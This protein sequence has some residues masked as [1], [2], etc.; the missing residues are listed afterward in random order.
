MY[1]WLNFNISSRQVTI[2]RWRSLAAWTRA[3]LRSPSM[4]CFEHS[5][6]PMQLRGL[7][8]DHL[9]GGYMAEGEPVI[10]QLKYKFWIY[11]GARERSFLCYMETLVR[12]CYGLPLRWNG[13]TIIQLEQSGDSR[14]SDFFWL[15]SSMSLKCTLRTCGRDALDPDSR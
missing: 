11:L 4:A 12:T 8:S 5:F 2:I 6:A 3:P 14:N 1:V 7:C 10:D 15:G 13:W 9:L